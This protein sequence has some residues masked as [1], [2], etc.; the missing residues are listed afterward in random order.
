MQLLGGCRNVWKDEENPIMKWIGL[1][2]L[3]CGKI[4]Q[5]GCEKAKS[6]YLKVEIKPDGY[7]LL[8]LMN[9]LD[10]SNTQDAIKLDIPDNE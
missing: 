5:C 7:Y 10:I 8:R 1:K 3:N 2:I 9:W 4:S 6:G